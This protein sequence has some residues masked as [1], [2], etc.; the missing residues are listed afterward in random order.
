MMSGDHDWHVFDVEQQLEVARIGNMWHVRRVGG[1]RTVALNDDEWEQVRE[2]GP[3]PE[4]ME[5]VNG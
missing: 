1:G 5:Q 2:P 3:D 4:I